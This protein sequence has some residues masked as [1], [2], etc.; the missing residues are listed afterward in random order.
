[1]KANNPKVAVSKSGIFVGAPGRLIRFSPAVV[2][3]SSKIR[4]TDKR[5]RNRFNLLPLDFRGQEVASGSRWAAAAC[6][7]RAPA[8]LGGNQ[9]FADCSVVSGLG[10][11]EQKLFFDPEAS[12]NASLPAHQKLA[13]ESAATP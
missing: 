13:N 9:G 8:V 11:N 12:H 7:C 1:M 6:P 5:C 10:V 3:G 2:N 4:E